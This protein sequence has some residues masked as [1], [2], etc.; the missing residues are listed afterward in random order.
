VDAV[1]GFC[2]AF[3]RDQATGM[4]LAQDSFTT[5][6]TA[7]HQLDDASRFS[8][9]MMTIT[10][11]TCLQWAA[12]QRRERT[13]LLQLSREPR[14]RPHRPELAS[15]VV[16]EVVAACP[17]EAL[18][19]VAERF[20]IDPGAT[21]HQIATELGLSQ[22]NVTTRLHRFREW[23]RRRMLTRLASALEES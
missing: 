1:V 9:W 21:T 18:R 14:P 16:A 8:G 15:T 22:S 4:D 17:D 19:A 10:R 11:R 6:F 5:A 2:A 20:Y 23:A 12:R 3:A 7:L 13:A